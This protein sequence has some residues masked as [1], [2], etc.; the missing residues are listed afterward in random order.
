MVDAFPTVAFCRLLPQQLKGSPLNQDL[1]Q[2][3]H[4]HT[5]TH[6]MTHRAPSEGQ[7][8]GDRAE[9][10]Q[11]LGGGG[12]GMGETGRKGP[13]TGE[14]AGAPLGPDA[15]VRAGLPQSL[16]LCN[17][18]PWSCRLRRD[19]THTTQALQA[20]R[21]PHASF[22]FPRMRAYLCTLLRVLSLSLT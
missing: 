11:L 5:H 13:R 16:P 3:P 1:Q 8:E 2:Q 10:E 7:R 18:T 15:R 22:Y 20:T 4:A 9:A 6:P 17:A 12:T 14:E 19:T 21:L